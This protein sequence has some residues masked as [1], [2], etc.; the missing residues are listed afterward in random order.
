MNRADI[1]APPSNWSTQQLAEF[2]VA[3]AASPDAPSAM[4]C[5]M[6]WA[7]EVLEAEV[8]AVVTDATSWR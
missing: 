3:V 8:A 2:L 1:T 4:L 7:S 5:A 6:Q